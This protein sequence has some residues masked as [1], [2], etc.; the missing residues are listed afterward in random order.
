MSSALKS[1]EQLLREIP[2]GSNVDI[3]RA[4]EAVE[5]VSKYILGVDDISL[6]Q[7]FISQGGNSLSVTAVVSLLQR[8]GYSRVCAEQLLSSRSLKS[9]ALSISSDSN[10]E[11][12]D[13]NWITFKSVKNLTFNEI[14]RMLNRHYAM[15][16]DHEPLSIYTWISHKFLEEIHGPIHSIRRSVICSSG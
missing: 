5:I 13:T 11:T 2:E 12:A 9:I 16:C 4:T 3:K 1:E 7:S 15:F 8:A 6:E 14:D 10:E